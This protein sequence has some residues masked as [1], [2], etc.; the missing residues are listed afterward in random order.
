MKINIYILFHFP[1]L[2]TIEE[3]KFVDVNIW[4]SYTEC[5]NL[6]GL[7]TFSWTCCWNQACFIF[8]CFSLRLNIMRW[9]MHNGVQGISLDSNRFRCWDFRFIWVQSDAPLLVYWVSDLSFIWKCLKN[10]LC[11]DS[12]IVNIYV[13]T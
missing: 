2:H 9:R 7:F 5:R 4:G 1:P 8:C 11:T 10:L 13:R 6:N 12:I 3:I